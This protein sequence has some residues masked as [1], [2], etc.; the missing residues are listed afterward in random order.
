MKKM[1]AALIAASA[2]AMAAPVIGQSSA[3]TTADDKD[4]TLIGCVQ[5][6]KSGGYWLTETKSAAITPGSSA[7]T[8]TA[9]TGTTGTS[10]ATT[11]TTSE[12]KDRASASSHAMWNLENGHDLDKYVNQTIQVTGR[13]KKSTSGDEVKGTTGREMEARDF[14]VKS[15]KLIAPSCS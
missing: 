9:T 14:D 11:T 2:V 6:N 5:K 8:T 12:D 7:A 4:M 10:G 13:A 3:T 15:V 1:F